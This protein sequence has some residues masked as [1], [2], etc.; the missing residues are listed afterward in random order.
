MYDCPKITTYSHRP[1]DIANVQPCVTETSL[2]V[3]WGRG[4]KIK[5]NAKEFTG[6]SIPTDRDILANRNVLKLINATKYKPL[7]T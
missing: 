1:W 7:D 4:H 6:Y 2:H 3:N 5:I